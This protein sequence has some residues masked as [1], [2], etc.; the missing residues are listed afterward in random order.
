M[1]NYRK[2][3]LSQD[4]HAPSRQ[5]YL[6]Q[7]VADNRVQHSKLRRFWLESSPA[8]HENGVWGLTWTIHYCGGRTLKVHVRNDGPKHARLIA[9]RNSQVAWAT[10]ISQESHAI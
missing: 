9:I 6:T 5:W 1:S 3:W 7:A 8:H 2:P 10:F 4:A